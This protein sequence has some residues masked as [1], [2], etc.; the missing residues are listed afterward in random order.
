M[1]M[2]MMNGN[3]NARESGVGRAVYYDGRGCAERSLA[4]LAHERGA[5]TDHLDG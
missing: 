5:H 2:G 3:G 1:G 4:K